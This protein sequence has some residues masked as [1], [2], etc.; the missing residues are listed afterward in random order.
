M[1]AYRFVLDFIEE[2]TTACAR[3]IVV[4]SNFTLGVFQDSFPLIRRYC[5]SHKPEVLYPAIEEKS[6]VKSLGF[7]ESVSDILGREVGPNTKIF[8]SLNRYERK[9]NIALA[10][11]S[12]SYFI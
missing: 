4:N 2:V 6:F 10:I 11:E 1:R 9:K 7:N 3:V 12:Y 5:R 8:T